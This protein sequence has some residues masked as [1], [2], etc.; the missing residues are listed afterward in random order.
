M[1]DPMPM[2]YGLF[3]FALA[4][5]ALRFMNVDAATLGS[6]STSIALTYAV[7]VAGIA[8]TAA[9]VLGIVRGTGYPA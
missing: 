2:A 7:L 5:F 9:G 1:A 3:G 6:N 8:Q 4:A